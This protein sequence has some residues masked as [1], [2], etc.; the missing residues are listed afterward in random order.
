MIFA[1]VTFVV[2]LALIVGVYW[3]FVAMPEQAEGAELRKRLKQAAPTAT[4][5][6]SSRLLKPLQQ[7]SSVAS[8]N[9]WL[10]RLG[11]ISQPLQRNLTQ[12]GLT[13]SVSTLLL[14]SVFL[15][16]LVY[17][18]V[19]YL[20]FSTALAMAAAAAVS[21]IPFMYVKRARNKRLNTFEEQFPEAVDLLGRALRAGH[22]FTTGVLMAAEEIPA[23]VGDEFKKLYDQQNFGMPL[24]DALHGFAERIPLIDARFFATAVLTQRETGGNLGEVLDNLA[25]V[26]RERFKVKRQV[27]VLTA[28]GRITGWILAG[29][30]PALA[31][32]M[33][34][35]APQHM[36]LLITDP[37]G[38]KMIVGALV[39]QV[40]GTLIIRKLVD[41]PY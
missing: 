33:F 8:L 2:V 10:T 34:A 14:S 6:K 22:A 36:T 29:F 37:L 13:M 11:H 20:V 39:L 7:F 26:I 15:A 41:I 18:G 38:I 1:V 32:A 28:H 35:I 4:A 9:A 5:T 31:A 12:A 21:L 19:R 27:R 30:P 17:L 23:P 3:L 25:S 24:P 40:T 16:A